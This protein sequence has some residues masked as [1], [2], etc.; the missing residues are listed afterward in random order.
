[1]SVIDYGEV[2]D[3]TKLYQLI[4]DLLDTYKQNITEANAIAHGDLVNAATYETNQWTLRW[5]G[6]TLALVLFLPNYWRWIE[7]GRPPTQQ[8]EGGVLYPAILD[9]IRVKHIVPRPDTKT[10]KVPTPERLAYMITRKIH[11]EGY[12]SPDHQGKH[13]LQ[14]AIDQVDLIENFKNA[15]VDQFNR[16]IKVSLHEELTNILSK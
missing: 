3:S 6:E 9:W 7:Q 5:K 11:R 16:E 15:L 10:N 8:S 12:F 13:L 2:T 14:N 4:R 1:M